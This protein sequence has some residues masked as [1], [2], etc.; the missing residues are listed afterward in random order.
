MAYLP[1]RHL[2]TNYLPTEHYP[3]VIFQPPNTTIELPCYL[4]QEKIKTHATF[5]A[6]FKF[7][8]G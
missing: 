6:N 5:A 1:I 7:E 2:P 4:S 3:P 8:K